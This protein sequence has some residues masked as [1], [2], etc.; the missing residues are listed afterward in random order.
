MLGK[1]NTWSPL[2]RPFLISTLAKSEIPISTHERVGP[3][4]EFLKTINFVKF[5]PSTL[6]LRKLSTLAL[7]IPNISAAEYAS[8]LVLKA[9]VGA[10]IAT[11][12]SIT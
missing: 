3:F 8:S 10:L 5:S 2:L 6:S 12:A 1:T 9:P 4:E 11:S 7:L